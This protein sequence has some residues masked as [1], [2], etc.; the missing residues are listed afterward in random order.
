M[1]PV[2]REQSRCSAYRQIVCLVAAACCAGAGCAQQMA[3]P[4]TMAQRTSVGQ[5][6]GTFRISGRV[7]D[8]QGGTPLARCVVAIVDVKHGFGGRTVLTGDDGHFLFEGVPSSKYRL[9]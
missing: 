9:S 3:T 2:T 5:G 6:M 1:M 4:L 8:A 7:V